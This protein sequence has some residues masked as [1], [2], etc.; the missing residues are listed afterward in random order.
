MMH[1]GITV[2]DGRRC[3]A[4]TL[5]KRICFQGSDEIKFVVFFS[6]A[7]SLSL[8]VYIEDFD[9]G[10]RSDPKTGSSALGV[11]CFNLNF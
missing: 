4:F 5:T 1:D 9:G 2:M 6:R 10:G 3:S 8:L 7:L 11:S